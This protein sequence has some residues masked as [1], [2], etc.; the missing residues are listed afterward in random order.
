MAVEPKEKAVRV[1]T[2]CNR[3]GEA[4]EIFLTESH[5]AALYAAFSAATPAEA[6]KI[7]E[8]ALIKPLSKGE[9]EMYQKQK[10]MHFFVIGDSHARIFNN[11][12]GFYVFQMKAPTAYNLVAERSTTDSRN[13]FY[14]FLQCTDGQN[15]ILVFGEVDCRIHI[16]YQSKKQNRPISELVDETVKRYGLLLED[17]AAKKVGF[18]VLGIPPAGYQDNGYGY[19]DY[20]TPVVM[21]EIFREF[22]EKMKAY[23]KAKN[24][25]YIDILSRTAGPDGLIASEYLL[26]DVHLNWKARNIIIDMLLEKKYW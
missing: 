19:P 2:T 17:L 10:G 5:V 25:P 24:F 13:I 1:T 12:S 20:P 7:C 16:Y 11:T 4:T 21:A 6:E 18:I 26:D 8:E 23:C 22:N 14:A 9:L 3:C 15:V